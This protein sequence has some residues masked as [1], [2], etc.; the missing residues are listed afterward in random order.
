[1]IEGHIDLT[2][3]EPFHKNIEYEHMKWKDKQQGFNFAVPDLEAAYNI[4]SL[5]VGVS[6]NVP[7]DYLELFKSIFNISSFSYAVQKM[8]PGNILPYHSDKYG[9]FLSQHPG[10]K[11]EN[12]IRYIVFLEDWQPGHI[13]EI[14]G[15]S[16]TKWKRGD[17]ISWRG[18]TPHLAANLGF[19]D[20][21]ALQITGIIK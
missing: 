21:Y 20:R 10:L 18:A 13:S 6:R 3:F 7:D 14:D 9:F 4:D 19:E 12:I 16:H 2:K 11:I 15:D 8:F 17:W 5:Q 1:M